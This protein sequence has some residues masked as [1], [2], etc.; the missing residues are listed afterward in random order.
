MLSELQEAKSFTVDGDKAMLETLNGYPAIT[1]KND[2][3]VPGTIPIVNIEEIK[4]DKNRYEIRWLFDWYFNIRI[5]N[6][7]KIKPR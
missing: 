1:S 6:K 2:L 3:G 5:T 4:K 7:I